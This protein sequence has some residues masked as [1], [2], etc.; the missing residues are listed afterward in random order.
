MQF[1]NQYLIPLWEKY[2]QN[3][4]IKVPLCLDVAPQEL[5]LI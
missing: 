5:A 2:L 4:K 3:K 1:V